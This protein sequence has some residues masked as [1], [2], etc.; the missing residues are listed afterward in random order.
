[1]LGAYY[2]YFC[3][4]IINLLDYEVVIVDFHSIFVIMW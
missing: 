2:L 1:M 4:K 3:C